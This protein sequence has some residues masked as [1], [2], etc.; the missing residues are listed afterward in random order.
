VPKGNKP[1]GFPIDDAEVNKH[2]ESQGLI[3]KQSP[4]LEAL[5]GVT[6]TRGLFVTKQFKKGELITS[7]WGAYKKKVP[8]ED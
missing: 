7:I 8:E 2:N 6:L 1:I 5:D 3:V 4:T